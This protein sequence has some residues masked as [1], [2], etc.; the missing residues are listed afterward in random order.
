MWSPRFPKLVMLVPVREGYHALST[1]DG[2]VNGEAVAADNVKTRISF[3][4]SN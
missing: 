1:A 3:E 4:T 2:F